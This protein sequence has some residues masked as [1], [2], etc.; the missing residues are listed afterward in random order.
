MPVIQSWEIFR[1][2]EYPPTFKFCV[3]W[4]DQTNPFFVGYNKKFRSL[5]LTDIFHPKVGLFFGFVEKSLKNLSK[6]LWK[7]FSPTIFFTLL[8]AEPL[9]YQENLTAS[10]LM[11]YYVRIISASKTN[12][13]HIIDVFPV[14]LPVSHIY[15]LDIIVGSFFGLPMSSIHVQH[16]GSQNF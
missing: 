11:Q 14:L 2:S 8:C 1:F 10:R 9:M 6:N 15:M 13:C 3:F 16:F 4:K 12:P 5:I 7:Y